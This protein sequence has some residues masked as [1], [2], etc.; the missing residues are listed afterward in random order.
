MDLRFTNVRI[1]Q[2]PGTSRIVGPHERREPLPRDSQHKL[3]L[4]PPPS[5][6][7]GNASRA[8]FSTG[9]DSLRTGLLVNPGVQP[10]HELLH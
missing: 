8:P 6:A 10:F 5:G 1:N 7:P 9:E 2:A 4:R 3:I